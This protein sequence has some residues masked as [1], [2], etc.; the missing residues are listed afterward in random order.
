MQ[1]NIPARFFK[2]HGSKMYS[3]VGKAMSKYSTSLALKLIA[4]F[5]NITPPM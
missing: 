1:Q 3:Y 5:L 4:I 2:Q